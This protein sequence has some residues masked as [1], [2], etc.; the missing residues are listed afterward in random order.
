[1]RSKLLNIHNAGLHALVFIY[2]PRLNAY[3]CVSS[4]FEQ[5]MIEVV[6]HASTIANIQKKANSSLD[7][8][9]LFDWLKEKNKTE[10]E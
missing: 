5:G 3:G 8:K 7:K 6:R 4:G 10:K 1:M 2:F 9:T